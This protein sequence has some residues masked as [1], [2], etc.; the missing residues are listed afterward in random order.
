MCATACSWI[1]GSIQRPRPDPEDPGGRLART[2]WKWGFAAE[3]FEFESQ[4]VAQHKT[5]IMGRR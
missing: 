3:S 1:L 2:R 4:K 5:D